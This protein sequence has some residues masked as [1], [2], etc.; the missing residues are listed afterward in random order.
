MGL[1]YHRVLNNLAQNYHIMLFH[2][3][4]VKKLFLFC[5]NRISIE[6]ANLHLTIIIFYRNYTFNV[7]FRERKTGLFRIAMKNCAGCGILVK[8]E[9]ECG[10]RA[11]LPDPQSY[12]S[13]NYRYSVCYMYQYSYLNVI[14][15][16]TVMYCTKCG[17]T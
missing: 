13:Q 10:I 16:L 1:A 7:L 2:H 11:L 6:G 3:T 14:A 5:W 9:R 15:K 8:K 4:E 17:R 12:R